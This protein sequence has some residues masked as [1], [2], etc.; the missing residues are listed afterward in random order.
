[1]GK[2]TLARIIANETGSA[3]EQLSAVSAGKADV[4]AIVERAAEPQTSL[5]EAL[6]VARK[7]LVTGQTVFFLDEI[8]RFNKAQQDFLLPY[9]ENGTII[10]IGATTENPS[11]SVISPLLSR[12]QVFVLEE[13]SLDDL[14]QIVKAGAKKL[15]VRINTKAIDYLIAFANGD[16]RKALNLLEAAVQLNLGGEEQRYQQGGLKKPKK[17]FP[18]LK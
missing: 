13:L 3:F 9:V 5:N 1:V 17:L 4:R 2:T 10:L 12:S 8:H 14:R 6:A 18:L 15:S 7:K 16:A 11:F